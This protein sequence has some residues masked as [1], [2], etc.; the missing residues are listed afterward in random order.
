MGGI[1]EVA[2]QATVS[3]ALSI[4]TIPK[5]DIAVSMFPGFAGEVS[6]MVHRGQPIRASLGRFAVSSSGDTPLAEAML[7]SARELVASKRQRKVLIIVTDGAPNCGASVRYLNELIAGHVDT[8]AIGIGS[9][10][11]ASYFRKW[12]VI[13]DVKELQHALFTIAGQFLELR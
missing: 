7:Y 1:Q 4:S 6:P 10:A 13:N 3:M 12:S 2:N 8:Y 11:V 9:T 5:C